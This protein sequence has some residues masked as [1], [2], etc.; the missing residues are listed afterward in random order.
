LQCVLWQV[1]PGHIH[2]PFALQHPQ[3]TLGLS[4]IIQETMF[5]QLGG[6]TFFRLDFWLSSKVFFKGNFL[7]GI[8]QGKVF[9]VRYALF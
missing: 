2:L 1:L 7:Q 8:F 6:E 3:V 9:A 4:N 5:A